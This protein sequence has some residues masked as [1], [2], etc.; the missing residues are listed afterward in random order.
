MSF[1]QYYININ[2]LAQI[3]IVKENRLA[4]LLINK[5]PFKP[6]TLYQSSRRNLAFGRK[7]TT[8]NLGIKNFL[9]QMETKMTMFETRDVV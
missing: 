9:D 2:F 4:F 6:T 7:G 3:I 5:N 1:K 8:P